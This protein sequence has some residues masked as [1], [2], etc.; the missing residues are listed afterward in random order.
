MNLN[1]HGMRRADCKP[2]EHSVGLRNWDSESLT[3]SGSGSGSCSFSAVL[4]PAES[5][6]LCG[7]VFGEPAVARSRA[8]PGSKSESLMSITPGRN[9]R[10][11]EKRDHSSAL[12]CPAREPTVGS[13]P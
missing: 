11:G 7:I 5:S 10:F 3:V 6:S 4:A 1:D 9:R 2:K 12:E 13:R 8:R